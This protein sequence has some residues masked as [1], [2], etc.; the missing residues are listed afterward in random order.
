MNSFEILKDKKLFIF[1]MSVFL[2]NIGS[3]LQNVALSWLA[4]SIKNASS[5]FGLISFL[6]SIPSLFFAFIGGYLAD[7]FDNRKILVVSQSVCLIVAFYLGV[8][9]YIGKVTYIEL[10]ILAFISGVGS[11]ISYP[12]YYNILISFVSHD[13]IPAL[14]ALNSLQFN[15]SR[16]IGPTVFSLLVLIIGIGGAFIL[17]GLSYI[18]FI[19]VLLTIAIS[20]KLLKS[21]DNRNF[22]S[23]ILS[24]FKYIVNEKKLFDVIKVVFIYSFFVLPYMGMLP[25]YIK[26]YI[27]DNPQLLGIEVGILG[28][29]SILGSLF[30]ALF[31]KNYEK[32]FERILRSGFSFSMLLGLLGVANN[33]Y[34]FSLIIFLMGFSM[35]LF[36]ASANAFIHLISKEDFRGRVASIFTSV[37]LGVYPVGVLV[38]GMVAEYV[39]IKLIFI[40]Q[41]AFSILYV[42]FRAIYYYGS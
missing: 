32:L 5:S 22:F 14:I 13:K 17:N 24:G 23:N 18:P 1:Y 40:V 2:S 20:E 10:A 7:N 38:T 42:M 27:E 11:A 4:L 36:Y 41:S 35:V 29:G 9:V 34:L 28:F 15:L 33:I 3:W 37:Y 6:N 8:S 21:R 30:I 26:N 25:Y 31:P 19:F 12:I 39:S 16:F